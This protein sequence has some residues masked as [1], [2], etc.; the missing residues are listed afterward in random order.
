M[1]PGS[2]DDE[3]EQMDIKKSRYS[4][5]RGFY[6]DPVLTFSIQGGQPNQNGAST[7]ISGGKYLYESIIFLWLNAWSDYNS[8]T[9]GP[10]SVPIFDSSDTNNKL[11][12]FFV[13]MDIL[14]PLCLKSMAVRYAVEVQASN[15]LST[16]AIL[17]P[18]HMTILKNFVEILARGVMGQALTYATSNTVLDEKN[19]ALLRALVSSDLI[20]EWFEGLFAILHP[21]HMRS[22]VGKYFQT[23]NE[24]ETEH[25]KENPKGLLEFQWTEESIHRVRSS[26]QLRLRAVEKLAVMPSFLALN[27]PSKFS[28]KLESQSAGIGGD[29]GISSWKVQYGESGHDHAS[30]GQPLQSHRHTSSGDGRRPKS[31]WLA[32]LLADEALS[33]CALSC[34]AVVAEAMAQV[35]LSND[36]TH[37]KTDRS[38]KKRKSFQLERRDLLMFQSLAI[39]AITAF[40]ELVLRRNA[41]DRR[42]QTNACRGRIAALYAEGLFT[43]SLK[44]VRWLA[45]MES[46]HKVRSLWML[47][48][49]YV[50]QEA[51]EVLIR[52]LVRSYCDPSVRQLT[53]FIT[54]LKTAL[55]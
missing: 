46:S 27:F 28:D 35:E 50:L 44:S 47:C 25:L 55:I 1:L 37:Q 14:L 12:D 5:F 34:E 33:V 38:H 53:S 6:D 8:G 26:R 39:H 51:P 32:R 23:L 31:G 2:D 48:L 16:R 13:N 19:A 42:F 22:L 3:D 45:R 15:D 21:D 30:E 43:Q 40:Y 17:D 20:V 29:S 24:C 9:G 4:A 36:K 54:D 18:E 10:N 52:N 11:F 41:M 7:L 49:V